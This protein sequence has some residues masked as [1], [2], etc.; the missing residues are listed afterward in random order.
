MPQY[1]R[2]FNFREHKG[3]GLRPTRKNVVDSKYLNTGTKGWNGEK[4]CIPN[5]KFPDGLVF[6]DIE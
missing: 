1:I 4:I 6:Y 3:K 2:N 5:I